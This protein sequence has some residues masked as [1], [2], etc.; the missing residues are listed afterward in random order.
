MK[1][2]LVPKRLQA[3]ALLVL[4]TAIAVTASAGLIEAPPAITAMWDGKDGASV[5]AALLGIATLGE[6]PGASARQKL[7]SGEAA[8]WLGVQDE[9]AGRADS[10]VAQWRRAV[11]LRGDFDEGFAL[12]EALAR[13][14]SAAALDEAYGIAFSLADQARMGSPARLPEA[15]AHFAWVRQLRGH[16]DSALAG[17]LEWDDE[18]RKKPM[19]TRRLAT[20]E[21]GAGDHARAWK[22]L[23]LLAARTRGRDATAESLLVLTQKALGLADEQR[24]AA[25]SALRAPVEKA[26]WRFTLTLPAS[27]DSL[28]AKDG[29]LVRWYRIAPPPGATS[30]PP[31]LLVLAPGDSL[32]AADSLAAAFAAAGRTVV[33]LPPRGT[34]VA[35]GPG[36]YGPEAWAG[37]PAAFASTI[38]ADAGRVMDAL[39]QKHAVPAGGWVVAAAGDAAPVALAIARA[40]RDTRAIVLVAPRLPVVEVAETR[41]RLRALGTRTFVQASPE[42][43]DALE[44]GDLLS[45]MTAPGQVRVADSGDR[46]RGVAIFRADP[47]V[48]KR[49]LDWLAEPAAKK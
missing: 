37:R 12:T 23:T 31:L 9:R 22:S 20:I 41:A 4:P 32:V 17:V 24:D 39:A 19:W 36:A 25:V 10:A 6:K 26:E 15:Q 3:L 14:A 35:L 34:G 5:R 47:K 33:L 45:R 13:R 43:P 30:K 44:L 29:F 28:R 46:G 8:W 1:R 27:L 16:P 38:A 18:L 21:H 48:A 40:R 49:L 11:A 42:E 2:V 7:E